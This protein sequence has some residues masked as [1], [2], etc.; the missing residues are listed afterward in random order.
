[1]RNDDDDDVI[2][3]LQKKH[4]LLIAP[5]IFQSFSLQGH[6][7]IWAGPSIQCHSSAEHDKVMQFLRTTENDTGLQIPNGKEKV[8]HVN[9]NF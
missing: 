4:D 9:N 8:K 5:L 6:I 1:M 7:V 2:N 3:S